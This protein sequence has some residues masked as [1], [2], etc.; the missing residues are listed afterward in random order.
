MFNRLANLPIG[1]KVAVAPLLLVACML[2]LAI[3]F[4]SGIKRQDGALNQLYEGSMR[5]DKLI[6]RLEQKSG[7][8][9]GNLYRLLSWKNSGI[10]ADKIAALDR[11]VRADLDDMKA[12]LGAIR[13]R[14]TGEVESKALDATQASTDGFAQA[15]R[16]VLDMY[17]ID[18]MSALVMM[19]TTERQFDQMVVRLG[20]FARLADA[21]T[22]RVY[23]DAGAVANQSR[24]NYYVVLAAFLVVGAAVSLIMA[25]LIAGPVGHITSVMGRLADGDVAITIP[26]LDN[27]DEIGAMA[28]AVAVF[29][30]NRQ[31]ADQ[32]EAEQRSL[33]EHEAIR[34][35][36]L[37]EATEVFA[38]DI[39]VILGE[40]SQVATR[41]T[42]MADALRDGSA[43]TGRETTAVVSAAQN[44]AANVQSVAA[45]ADQLGRA[46]DEISRRASDATA[47]IGRAVTRIDQAGATMATL[48]DTAQRI[49]E[50]IG[51]IDVIAAQ[52]NLLAL[53]ATI[54]A[55]RAGDAGKGFAV[56]AGEVKNLAGQTGKAT[57]EI[58]EQVGAIQSVAREAVTTITDIT[59]TIAQVNEVAASIAAA[60][61]EQSAATRE[62]ARNVTQ[63][64]SGNV[65]VTDSIER[66]S[67]TACKTGELGEEMARLAHGLGTHMARLD[68]RVRDFLAKAGQA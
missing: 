10:E 34:A 24:T 66:V 62:I 54:E 13:D 30:D 45:A 35:K 42:D 29:R 47:I 19:L 53:N 7:A 52:T 64:A 33:R 16:D 38:A 12:N 55:A 49:G 48:S 36:T 37:A 15:V 59:S 18:E 28:R 57:S 4:T 65:S 17:G 27:R 67:A 1:I 63:A 26:S 46:E 58:T 5:Q 14:V 31:R 6:A 41:V 23:R 56:V 50:I 32:L 9:Q 51:L 68:G 44:S 11:R 20:E 40:V 61:E 39:R 3:I 43:A 60:V 25:R 21:D 22:E 2:L 8:V